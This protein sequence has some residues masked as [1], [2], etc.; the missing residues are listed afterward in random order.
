VEETLRSLRQRLAA[1][2]PAGEQPAVAPDPDAVARFLEKVLEIAE[3]APK[4]TTS[5]PDLKRT[6]RHTAGHANAT[7]EAPTR[8][9]SAGRV[10]F[11]R[12]CDTKGGSPVRF[13][14]TAVLL[15]LAGAAIGCAGSNFIR[16]TPDAF[17][18]GKT[19]QEQVVQQLGNPRS[20]GTITKNDAAFE[21]IT[22]AYTSSF[23][24]LEKGVVP[25]RH[26]V[27]LFANGVLVGEEYTSSFKADHTYFDDAKISSIVK[28]ET[29]RADVV[30]L[31]GAPSCR[32]IPPWVKDTSGGAIGYL[33]RTTRGGGFSGYT[34][35]WKAVIFSFDDRDRVS[36]FE[37]T[38]VGTPPK[39]QPPQQ[40]ETRPQNE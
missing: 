24:P 25:Q 16:P 10:Y 38:K 8:L 20:Q 13:T 22:Y 34:H 17:T 5:V 23:D 35:A 32:F 27:F 15:G 6:R 30:R 33:Y 11:R 7:F 26:L 12:R 21:T 37:L 29:T 40:P 2:P 18:L 28:G 31:L 4:L 36:D 1:K 9:R 3:T 19:T 14:R 39:P